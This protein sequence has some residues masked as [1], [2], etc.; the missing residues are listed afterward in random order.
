MSACHSYSLNRA[1]YLSCW[2]CLMVNGKVRAGL[3]KGSLGD[4][5]FW[6]LSL[7]GEDRWGGLLKGLGPEG[8]RAEGEVTLRED[9]RTRDKLCLRLCPPVPNTACFTK[10]SK[11]SAPESGDLSSAIL[12]SKLTMNPWQSHFPFWFLFSHL[13]NERVG[14]DELSSAFQLWLSVWSQ[15]QRRLRDW[16]ATINS[17]KLF[18]WLAVRT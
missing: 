7:G 18:L 10:L 8:R 6:Y 17:R 1:D 9:W 12:T 14:F 4:P 5:L 2:K 16:T 15:S 3:L 11:G 13:E